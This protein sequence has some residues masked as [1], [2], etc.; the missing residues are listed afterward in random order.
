V[1]PP[2]TF[3]PVPTNRPIRLYNETCI[4]CSR[5]FDGSLKRTTEHVIGK[6][7]VPAGRLGRWNLI[8]SACS[9][10]NG[11]KAALE[12]EV[13]AVTMRPDVHGRFA[14]DDD[15]LRLEAARKGRGAISSR[16][17]VPVG[18]SQSQF[19][20][21]MP[22]M[23]GATF[24]FNL[25]GP[26]QLDESRAFLLALFQMRAFFYL[27]TYCP[28][29]RR[30]GFWLGEFVPVEALPKGD[31]GN[32]V[33][34]SFQRLVSSWDHRL[35]LNAGE[36]FYRAC[37]R[38]SPDDRPLWAWAIEWNANYR[39]VGFFGDKGAVDDA[40]ANLEFPEM[41]AIHQHGKEEMRLRLNTRLTDADDV[42]FA[43][44]STAIQADKALEC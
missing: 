43:W 44:P 23:P 19:Q 7:F 13:S 9:R 1:Q 36:G 8:A 41:K 3:Q 26:P 38:R 21:E 42:L 16:T 17:G 39:L 15:D 30:G 5:P 37:M 6:R 29:R 24:R 4:Y 40:A 34:R 2:P 31:W 22:V 14:E 27:T 10:C 12:G 35:L 18:E 11:K 20:V 28:E 33:L 25:T 32:P